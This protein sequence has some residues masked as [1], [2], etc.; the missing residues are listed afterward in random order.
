MFINLA[1]QSIFS[2]GWDKLD[3]CIYE[4]CDDLV[5]IVLNTNYLGKP[6]TSGNHYLQQRCVQSAM[7]IDAARRDTARELL[8]RLW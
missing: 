7:W 5:I 3:I 4:Q 8:T 6:T 2:E 1:C